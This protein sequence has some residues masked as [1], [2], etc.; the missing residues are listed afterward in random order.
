MGLWR[1]Q[2]IV[3]QLKQTAWDIILR[4]F[5]I[6]ERVALIGKNYDRCNF[7]QTKTGVGLWWFGYGEGKVIIE[8]SQRWS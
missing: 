8:H 2:V 4:T 6:G 1:W 3:W 5:G 7:T